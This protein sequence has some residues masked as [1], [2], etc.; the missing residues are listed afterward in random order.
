MKDLPLAAR[1]FVGAVLAAGALTLLA[2]WPHGI[3]NPLLFAFLLGC[4]SLASALKVSLP[5]A[6]SGSTMSVSYAVDFAALLL[7]GAD[8][9]M[10][11]AAASAFSQCTFR[12]QTKSAPY[13]TL[14][15]MAS[16]VLTVKAAGLAYTLLG[17]TIGGAVHAV[18]DHQAAG[19]RGDDVFRFQHAVHRD[20]D[21][22]VDAAVDRPRLERKLPVERAELFRRCAGGGDR[23][24]RDRSRRLLDGVTRGGAALSDL[25]DL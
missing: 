21:R 10:L 1:L 3:A 5:L 12:T 16:L 22:L 15:S 24:Q 13:R 11:V 8:Q 23:G 9:T 4:S 6:S 18:L 2:F 19:R 20:R 25:P 14:F 7:L 17:G